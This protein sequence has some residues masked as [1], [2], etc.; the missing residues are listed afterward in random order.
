MQKKII[1]SLSLRTK[2]SVLL[3]NIKY[4]Y[5]KRLQARTSPLMWKKKISCNW[6]RLNSGRHIAL[7]GAAQMLQGN[8]WKD[9]LQATVDIS[10]NNSCIYIL[11]S[12]SPV[13]ILSN[14]NIQIVLKIAKTPELCWWSSFIVSLG[15]YCIC[16]SCWKNRTPWLLK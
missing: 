9:N 7:L 14:S 2:K 13:K 1:K 5:S 10:C 6:Y 4:A 3:L 15:N 8:H 11:C 12:Q 16:Y